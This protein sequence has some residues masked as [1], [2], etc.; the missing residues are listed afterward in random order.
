MED[1]FG[2]ERA[3]I[4]FKDESGF[5]QIAEEHVIIVESIEIFVGAFP[6]F[7]RGRLTAPTLPHL[8][9]ELIV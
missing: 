9:N 4:Y 8:P 7:Y 6:D 5:P 1:L 3:S 2:Q